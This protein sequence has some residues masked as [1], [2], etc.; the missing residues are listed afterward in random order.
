[1]KALERDSR[2]VATIDKIKSLQS[3]LLTE[4]SRC[5]KKK[6]YPSC[7]RQ[8]HKL[9]NK[10]KVKIKELNVARSKVAKLSVLLAEGRGHRVAESLKNLE[11]LVKSIQTEV[12]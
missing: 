7:A 5:F 4:A 3:L 10:I 9:P 8:V 12:K 1:M 11:T 2:E 6:V